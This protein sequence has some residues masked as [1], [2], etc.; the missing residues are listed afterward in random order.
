M[1]WDLFQE[2]SKIKKFVS[3]AIK[4]PVWNASEPLSQTAL[5]S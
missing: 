2:F 1:Y 5:P 4:E 3:A